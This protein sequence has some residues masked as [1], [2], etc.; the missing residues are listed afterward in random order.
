MGLQRPSTSYRSRESP[1][2]AAPS[3]IDWVANVHGVLQHPEPQQGKEGSNDSRGGDRESTSASQMVLPTL[4]ETDRT[5]RVLPPREH[6]TG[7]VMT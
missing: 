7:H 2:R 1:G 5:T 6:P 3:V 4:S